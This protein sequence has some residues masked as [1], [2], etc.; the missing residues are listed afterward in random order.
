MPIAINMFADPNS[1]TDWGVIY[2][3]SVA[4][5]L[6][7]LLIFLFFQKYLVEGIATTGLKA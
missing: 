2:A 6:P 4:S 1:G 7:V 5:I 3:M